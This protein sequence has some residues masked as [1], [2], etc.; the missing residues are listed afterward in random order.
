MNLWKRAR[1]QMNIRDEL[2][3]LTTSDIYSLMLF[4][5]Y[6]ANELPEYSS[7]SQ[8]SYILDKGSLLKLCE[9][10]G[11]TTI[12]IPTISELETLLSALLVYQLVDIENR[13][14]DEVLEE[15]RVKTG[16]CTDVKKHYYN[17]KCI[18]SNYNFNSGR[19]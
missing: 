6:K 12:R 1:C 4:A 19:G 5:L 2:N 14:L 10:Y 11:G 17:I 18:L 15:I 13:C 3:N 9:F 16:S 8:L 7:L